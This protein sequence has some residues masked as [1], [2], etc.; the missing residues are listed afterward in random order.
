MRA[1]HYLVPLVGAVAVIG[2]AAC[3]DTTAA[4]PTLF[5][6][7]TTTVDVAA[8]SGD[9]A[10]QTVQTMTDNEASAG[11]TADYVG[12]TAP[13]A[14]FEGAPVNN[15]TIARTRTCLDANGAVVAGCS[16]ISSVRK[17]ATHVTA[18]GSRGQTTTTTGGSAAIWTGAVHRVADDATTRIFN[19]STPAVETSRSHSAVGTAHDT[20]SFTEGTLT[21]KTSEVAHDS[22]KAVIFTLPRS[23][24]P[25]PT[26]GSIVRVD[27]VHVAL[28]K[29][30]LSETKDL[31]RVVTITFP[32]DAQGNVVLTVNAKTCNLNLVT[33]AVTGCK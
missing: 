16:P 4:T 28:T 2:L 17:I 33:H 32:A 8:S 22:V 20:T 26:S 15:L 7:S 3:G 21:R 9:A 27:S 14:F 11:F 31:V 18:D 13:T 12:S 6:D 1:A 19:T 5:N 23:S 25:F 24:N 29:G 10:A 30:T